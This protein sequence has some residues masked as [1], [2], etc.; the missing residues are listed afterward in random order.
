MIT[1]LFYSVIFLILSSGLIFAQSNGFSDWVDPNYDYS[2]TACGGQS[3]AKAG[4]APSSINEVVIIAVDSCSYGESVLPPWFDE[5]MSRLH[6]FFDQATFG[7]CNYQCVV[8][9]KDAN[10]AFIMPKYALPSCNGTCE[11]IHLLSNVR[12]V[13][14]QADAIYNFADYDY[15]NDGI[16]YVHF[17]SIGPRS[18]GVVANCLTYT[19]NDVGSGG[20]KIRIV[21]NK[22]SRG[23]K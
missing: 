6:D 4:S 17:T 23:A 14:Q 16:V 12:N 22:Q 21:V 9:K 10:H 8:L 18:G 20:N 5:S 3:L 1:R 15:D 2:C 13:I 11:H 7:H 19:T